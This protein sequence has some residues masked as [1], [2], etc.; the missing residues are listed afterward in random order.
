[1]KTAVIVCGNLRTFLMPLR[2]NPSLRVCDIFMRN[3]VL[4]NNADVFA[5]TDT[6]SFYYDGTEYFSTKNI[7]VYHGEA[8]RIHDKVALIDEKTA[9]DIIR[10]ELTA[11]V[12]QRLKMLTIAS[13]I[14]VN[15]DAKFKILKSIDAGGASPTMMVQQ[16]LK[17]KRGYESMANYEHANGLRYDAIIKCRFDNMYAGHPLNI[18]NYSYSNK[19]LYCPG[20][21]APMVL[22]WYAFGLRDV[23][24][25]YMT[26][27]DQLGT[28]IPQGRMF[29]HECTR[30]GVSVEHGENGNY[31]G[32]ACP[33]CRR[34]DSICSSDIALS[35][36]HH[37]YRMCERNGF[38]PRGAGYYVYV[39]RF[40]DSAP[41][42]MGAYDILKGTDGFTLNTHA[43]KNIDSVSFRRDQ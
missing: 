27:Y 36:E 10:K 26:L 37:I 14:E 34:S 15:E 38:Q 11:I 39:Y 9:E 31:G 5:L 21:K 13:A 1:M 18:G 30:C 22:D 32:T 28:I 20:I 19:E 12:G 24:S 7:D 35:S 8:F 4:P 40:K 42:T 3:I 33:G 6:T 43:G 2:E 16:Y 17:L 23:M 41:S 25:H 29:I